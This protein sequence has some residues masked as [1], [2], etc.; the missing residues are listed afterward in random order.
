M[1]IDGAAMMTSEPEP[2][3]LQSQYHISA[4]IEGGNKHHN[5]ILNASRG[6]WTVRITWRIEDNKF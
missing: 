4:E 6:T 1:L 5:P 2:R 3:I